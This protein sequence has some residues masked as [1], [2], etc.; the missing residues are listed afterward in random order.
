MGIGNYK[1]NVTNEKVLIYR[2]GQFSHLWAD[3]F[4]RLGLD[5]E[6]VERMG[7]GTPPEEV[8]KTLKNDTIIKLK[9]SVL[10]KMKLQQG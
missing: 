10:P 5:V 3:M 9:L 4:K 7:T 1:Y 8:E 2:Y 6:L